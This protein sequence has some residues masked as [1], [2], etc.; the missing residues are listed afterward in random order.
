LANV[1]VC[2][3]VACN[4]P[5]ARRQWVSLAEAAS[6]PFIGLIQEQYP[7]YLEYRDATFAQGNKKPRVIEE[8]DGWAGLF[9]SVLVPA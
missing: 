8:H 1:R 6:E 9:S 3:A 4:H 2:L 7:R 5:F